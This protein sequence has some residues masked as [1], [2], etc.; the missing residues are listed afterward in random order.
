MGAHGQNVGVVGRGEGEE[1]HSRGQEVRP[2]AAAAPG[3]D[4]GGKGGTLHVLHRLPEVWRH[5]DAGVAG[6]EL[7][8]DG[9]AAAGHVW[10]GFV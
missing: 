9:R 4:T 8:G 7:V 5:Q 2:L 6:E 10:L 1:G 3:S